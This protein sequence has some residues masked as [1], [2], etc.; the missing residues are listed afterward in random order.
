M[1]N[2]HSRTL[3]LRSPSLMMIIIIIIINVS[4]GSGTVVR[5]CRRARKDWLV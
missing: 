2:M 3:G 1:I 4:K 5:D